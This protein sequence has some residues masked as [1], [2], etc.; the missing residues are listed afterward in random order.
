M[1]FASSNPGWGLEFEFQ[2]LDVGARL[3]SGKNV[4]RVT[5]RTL[6]TNAPFCCTL[7]IRLEEKL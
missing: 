3:R 7:C 5:Y 6:I 1:L 4:S 2:I